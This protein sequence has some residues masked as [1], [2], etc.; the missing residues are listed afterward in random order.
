MLLAS[1]LSHV[2][3][4]YFISSIVSQEH[5]I[6]VK[7]ITYQSRASH[8][9][10]TSLKCATRFHTCIHPGPNSNGCQFFVTCNKTEWLD[11]KHVVFGKVLCLSGV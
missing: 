6:S 2:R 10:W 3:H 5:N 1:G 8:I 9:R 11:N 4:T 7:S